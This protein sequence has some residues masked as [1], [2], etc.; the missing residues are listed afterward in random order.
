M[1]DLDSADFVTNTEPYR[2]EL[3]AHCYR[4]LGSVHDAEDLVQE[5][6]LRAWRAYGGFEHRSSVRTWLYQI[7]TNACLTALQRRGRRVMPSGLRRPS[8]DPYAPPLP[9]G[10]RGQLA[11]A[12]PRRAGCAGSRRPGGG[13]DGAGGLRLAL[14]ASLQHL[15][16]RQRAVLL[17]RTCWRSPP[18]RSRPC[19]TSARPRSRAPC[20]A[21]GPGWRRCPR[22]RTGS[23]SPD[24]AAGPRAARPLHRRLR[25]RRCGRAEGGAPRGRR[26]G[27]GR[28]PHLVLR[29][30]H[31]PAFLEP[32]VLGSPG[33]WRMV[34]TTANGSPSPRRTSRRLRHPRGVR[35][36]V[37]TP[38]TDGIARIVVFGDP[39][40]VRT[41]GFPLR[42]P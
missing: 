3:L 18:P 7:A 32:Q 36:R 29:A 12:H 24:G 5:T 27:D 26:A 6:Y 39:D 14:I 35:M 11:A 16:A 10:V 42:R 20:S 22:Q 4:M 33:G 37:L 1:P 2:R 25:E 19:S 41:F 30:A 9:A 34:P 40:L 28:L 38:G 21:P 13:R 8:D 23:P 15:P 17:L 31:V